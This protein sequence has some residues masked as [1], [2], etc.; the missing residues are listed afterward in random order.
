[1][2]YSLDSSQCRNYD[3]SSRREW[4]LTNGLGGYAMGTVAGSNTRRYH[5]HLVVADPAP[6]YRLA[7]LGGVEAYVQGDAN[8]IGISCHQYQGAVNPEGHHTLESFSV[9]KTWALWRHRVAGMNVEKRLAMH[10]GV[11]AC[12]IEYCNTGDGPIAL[13]LRPLVQHKFY[14]ENFR[15]DDAYPHVQAFPKDRTIV[16]HEGRTLLLRHDRAQRLPAV[17]W[18]YRF[19]YLR[20]L[21]RGLEGRDDLFCPCELRYELAPGE[22][23]VLVASLNDEVDPWTDWS[24][25][26]KDPSLASHLKDAAERFLVETPTRTSLIA[27]YPWFTD[28]GRDTMIS[29]PGICLHTGRVEMA[30]QIILDYAKQMNQGLIPNRFVDDGEEPEFNTVDATLWFANAA[31]KTLEAGW[32]EAFAKKAMK[33]LQ[34]MFKWH[35]QGTH[36][37]IGVDPDDGLLKQGT[38]GVQLT[39]MDAKIGD[40]VV[41]PRHGKP[42]EINGLW[43]NALRVMEWLAGKLKMDPKP[44]KEAANRAEGNFDAKF[45]KESLGYYMDTADPDDAS[46]RPN[47]LIAMALPFGP[48]KGK[49]A[50]AALAVISRELLTPA[51]LRTLA[52]DD[53]KYR[54]RFEGPLA[55]LDAAY[56]QGTVWPWLMGPYV[57]AMVRLTGDKVEARRLLKNAKDLLHEYG[58]GGIAEV[59]DG[60]KPRNAGGC[61]WQA[62][63]VAE[64]L[65]AWVEDADGK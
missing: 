40:W 7:L 19:E 44:Y 33:A 26:P 16:E 28:W 13:Q 63:S 38:E 1:M 18:Y 27:G 65:R 50:E 32:D 46:L 53:V 54:G 10:R 29:L 31:Y 20:E 11:N 21:E 62:W 24:E 61:P 59:Y 34:E 64:W 30:R 3:L 52:P 23:A 4:I 42:V 47:Q 25:P 51:G 57:S 8:P 45:W 14:H 39:W 37:G 55:E 35:M 60:D 17:G 5:G 22:S 56:H 9:T 6:A 2:M 48:A 15:S 58:L 49:R 36:Y 43:I 12:T 41:T